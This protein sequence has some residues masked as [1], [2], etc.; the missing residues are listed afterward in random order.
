VRPFFT[1]FL[2]IALLFLTVTCGDIGF[3]NVFF[4]I[5]KRIGK[6]PGGFIIL[7]DIAKSPNVGNSARIGRKNS[8]E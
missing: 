8:L 1:L 6:Y 7:A 5:E 4:A 3:G 2:E